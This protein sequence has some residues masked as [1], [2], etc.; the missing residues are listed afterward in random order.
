MLVQR[1]RALRGSREGVHRAGSLE[2]NKQ[3]SIRVM[4]DGGRKD[5]RVEAGGP[6]VVCARTGV[7]GSMDMA[8]GASGAGAVRVG[9][10]GD[11]SGAE[12]KGLVGSSV[13]RFA[14]GVS[15]VSCEK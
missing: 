12:G 3:L 13:S 6:G 11:A 15:S 14:R 2:I 1:S 7:A 10:R 5:V 9:R 4:R 8:G